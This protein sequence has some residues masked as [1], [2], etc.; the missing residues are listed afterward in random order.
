MPYTTHQFYTVTHNQP[1]GLEGEGLARLLPP[2]LMLPCANIPDKLAED[3]TS[4]E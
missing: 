3:D 1:D 4:F 2:R